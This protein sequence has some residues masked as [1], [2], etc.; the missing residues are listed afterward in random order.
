MEIKLPKEKKENGTGTL[1]YHPLTHINPSPGHDVM[2]IQLN[3]DLTRIDFVYHVAKHRSYIGGWIRI[4]DT[5][6]IRPAGSDL[7]LKMVS[8]VNIPIAPKKLTFTRSTD[9]ICYTLYFPPLPKGTK[10]IDIIE[11]ESNDPSYFNFYGVAVE[12]IKKEPIIIPN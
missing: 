4:H 1:V 3:E 7:K 6:Y 11:M 12:S 5:C 9:I 10:S 2:R 8:A